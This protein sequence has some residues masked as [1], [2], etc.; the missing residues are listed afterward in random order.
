MFRQCFNIVLL[1][2]T[3]GTTGREE[4]EQYSRWE[5]STVKGARSRGKKT[6]THAREH[7]RCTLWTRT[8]SCTRTQMH[9]RY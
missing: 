9:A 7:A 3:K 2:C 4:R 8:S 5:L 1:I 6:N